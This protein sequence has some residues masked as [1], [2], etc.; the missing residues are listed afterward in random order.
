MLK[1]IE[2]NYIDLFNKD[3]EQ[4]ISSH[5]WKKKKK[6]YR[7]YYFIRRRKSIWKQFSRYR[8]MRIY[9]I[10]KNLWYTAKSKLVTNIFFKENSMLTQINKIKQLCF[11]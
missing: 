11:I 7:K 3:N 2:L 4:N 10:D 6:F 8:V 1:E 5:W 9:L